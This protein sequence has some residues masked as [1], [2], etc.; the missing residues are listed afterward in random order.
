VITS[1]ESVAWH[2]FSKSIQFENGRYVVAVPWQNERPSLPN[3]RPLADKRLESTARKLEKNPEIAEAYQ[4][5]IEEY[6][7][8]NYIYRAP[9]DEPKPVTEWLLP[10]SPVVRADWTTTKTRIGFD[11]SAKFQGKSLNSEALPGPTDRTCSVF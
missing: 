9:L 2:K 6:L 11:A 7:E 5:V 3:K 4:K 1:D 10:H 8:K